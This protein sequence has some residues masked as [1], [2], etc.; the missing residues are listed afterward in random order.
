MPGI[1]KEPTN[2]RYIYV[3]QT[4]NS[5]HLLAP[6]SR[7]LEISLDNT[8]AATKELKGFFANAQ[9]ELE[10]YKGSLEHDLH[11]LYSPLSAEYKLIEQRYEQI[12]D[13]IYALKQ[14]TLESFLRLFDSLIPSSNVHS[15]QLRPTEQDSESV[16]YRPTFSIDR[17]NDY[18]GT[19]NSA[20][21]L[22]MHETYPSIVSVKSDPYTSLCDAVLGDLPE[23]APFTL[24]QE[25]LHKKCRALFA[26]SVDFTKQV[27]SKVVDKASVDNLMGFDAK[28]LPSNLEYIEGLIGVC[29]PNLFEIVS[30]SPFY[31]LPRNIEES[32]KAEELSLRTQFLLAIL[33]T[34]CKAKALSTANFGVRLDDSTELSRELVATVASALLSGGSVEQVICNFFNDYKDE[35]DLAESLSESDILAITQKFK[36]SYQAIS[37]VYQNPHMDDFLILERETTDVLVKLVTHKGCICVNF[38]DLT[39]N[40]YKYEHASIVN[41]SLANLPIDIPAN[42]QWLATRFDENDA[43]LFAG[44]DY[45][46]LDRLPRPIL[47]SLFSIPMFRFHLFLYYVALGKQDLAQ[48]ILTANKDFIQE[49]LITAGTFRDIFGRVFHCTGYEYAWWA[50]DTHMRKMLEQYMSNSTKSILLDKVNTIERE[51]LEYYLREGSYKTP[52]YD[53]SFILRDLTYKELKLLQAILGSRV[54][55]VNNATRGNYRQ[56]AFTSIEFLQIEK[57]LKAESSYFTIPL[58]FKGAAKAISIKLKFDFNSIICRFHKY[59]DKF[60]KWDIQINTRSKRIG[61]IDI[62]VAQLEAPAHIIH[63]YCRLDRAFLPLPTFDEEELPRQETFIAA[64]NYTPIS[65]RPS[66]YEYRNIQSSILVR[67]NR[68]QC[69]M[70]ESSWKETIA[71]LQIIKDSELPAISRL[72]EVRT[73]DLSKS[74]RVLSEPFYLTDLVQNLEMKPDEFSNDAYKKLCLLNIFSNNRPAAVSRIGTSLTNIPRV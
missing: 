25:T 9:K 2:P 32:L 20:L 21:Y 68:S 18:E 58:L 71:L 52:H 43:S 50:L 63:E 7:G 55:K 73:A 1:F 69:F 33:N 46:H 34:Y 17:T 49:I 62:Y 74:H 40:S 53:M 54:E 30:D 70:P 6:L 22:A 24:I 8:C 41:S 39:S 14:Q 37:D 13:Y 44:V 38:A 15:V 56:I 19:P 61:L 26:I 10:D 23:D 59:I 45:K 36:R 72:I 11:I 51:G 35:M 57:L 48:Q 28:H 3:Q 31:D 66:S 67:Q 12:I 47:D 5:V 29:S 65:F 60:P 42:N 64:P 16:V 4:I 27:N